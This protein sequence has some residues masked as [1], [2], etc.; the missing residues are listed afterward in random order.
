MIIAPHPDDEVFGCGGLIAKLTK[1]DKQVEV[2]FLTD[3]GASHEKCCN[4]ADH[5]IGNRRRCLARKA[6]K[7]IGLVNDNLI[8]LD[9][10]DGRLP[11]RI[12]PAFESVA[13]DIGGHLKQFMPEA[14]FCPHPFENWADHVAAA[15]ITAAAINRLKERLRPQLFYYCVWFWHNMPLRRALFLNWKR[16]R[17]LDIR[18]QISVKKDAIDIYLQDL[19]PCGIPWVGQLPAP[20]VKAVADGKE[21]YFESGTSVK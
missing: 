20:L 18:E 19:A 15:E 5:R 17:L 8:F 6:G 16:A 11:R 12:D 13:D 7:V 1:M 3:G 9:G 21:L 4:L 2:L 10:K 14:V